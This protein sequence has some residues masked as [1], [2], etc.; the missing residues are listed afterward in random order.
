MSRLPSL[1]ISHGSPMVLIE[2]GPSHE[3]LKELGGMLPRPRA[4]L[5]VTAHWLTQRP[6]FSSGAA[7]ETVYDFYNF[8]AK[9][10]ALTYPAPGA[11][12]VAQ[13]AADLLQKHDIAAELD[14]AYGFDHGTWV[15]F[16]LTYP[17]ADIPI[18]QMSVQ[19]DR[20]AA[21]HFKLGEALAPLRDDG[22]LIVGSGAITHNLRELMAMFGDGR[23][24][25][26]AW[27]TNFTDWIFAAIR[28]GRIDD[29]IDYQN[30][31]P[32][33]GHNHPTTEHFLPLF[34]ALGA[35]GKSLTSERLHDHADYGVL[36]MDA[37]RFD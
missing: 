8:P 10:Y 4:I 26:P 21:W 30:L 28:N 15:P 18:V 12:K 3:F 32:E 20:D 6:A 33:A 37:Y 23:S 36:S 31:A 17:D 27:I 11:P 25:P 14:P 1:F 2:P 5:C 16:K 19:A 24:A 13:A 34:V 9:L 29:L 7:P 35:A 22:V